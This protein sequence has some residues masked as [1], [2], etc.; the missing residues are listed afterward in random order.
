MFKISKLN[1]YNS[2]IINET[3]EFN[4]YI[5]SEIPENIYLDYSI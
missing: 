5:N 3:I 4:E 1:E 2:E